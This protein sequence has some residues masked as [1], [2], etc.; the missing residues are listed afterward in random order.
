MKT[1]F[2]FFF[3]LFCVALSAQE[4]K[5]SPP[6]TP[7]LLGQQE[8]VKLEA[9]VPAGQRADWFY[10]DTLP[11][12]EILQRS[13]IDT[14]ESGGALL[15]TQRLFLTSWDSGEW[16]FPTVMV[17]TVPSST[18]PIAVTYTSP[19]NPQQ[20]YHDIKGIV[21]TKSSG[22][23]NWWWYVIGAAVVV[24]LFLL[25]FPADKKDKP[26]SEIDTNAYK[27]AMQQL[28]KLKADGTASSAP[29]TF[30]TEA[31]NIFR[32]YL[33]GAKG[34]QSFSKTTTDLSVQLQS[35]GLPQAQYNGLVQT[36]RLSDTVKFAEYRPDTEA[37]ADSLAVIQQSI[38]AIEG[39]HAV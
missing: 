12:F 10:V 6:K 27:K 9:T 26:V 3:L 15:L 30:Y 4:I 39:R 19:W 21:P 17:A 31:V 35:L 1:A 34:I 8:E 5:L 24:A 20:P 29:K 25:F 11:H 14:Q 13:K 38:T 32:A 2:L 23:D 37:A 36:L 33:K 22:R 16:D 28:E 18:V 7:M